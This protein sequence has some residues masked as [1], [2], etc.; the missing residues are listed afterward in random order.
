MSATIATIRR[1]ST[2]TSYVV[3]ATFTGD[4]SYPSGG[5]TVAAKDFGLGTIT[6]IAHLASNTAAA[7]YIVEYDYEAGKLAFYSGASVA[8][9]EPSLRT[10]MMA[11]CQ[12]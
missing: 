10:S 3:L 4:T 7:A 5:Y 12:S 6:G 2:G 8:T 9:G 1:D 11:R